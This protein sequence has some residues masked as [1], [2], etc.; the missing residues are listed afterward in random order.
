LI[1]FVI[2][3]HTHDYERLTLNF[4]GN[5]VHFLIVGGAG[6]GLE[7][8]DKS[9]DYPKMDRVIKEHHFGILDLGKDSFNLRVFNLEGEI[10]DQFSEEE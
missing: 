4:S 8:K 6:G 3:G 9:S 1:D 2:A 10:I 5:S 7:P